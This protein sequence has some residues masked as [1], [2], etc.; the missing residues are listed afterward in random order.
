MSNL[1]TELKRRNVIRV[2]LLYAVFAW[3]ILQMADVLIP[4]LNL[5]E[6][7]DRLTFFLL[8]IGLPLAIFFAWAYEIT[9]EGLKREK[10]V[11]RSKS[12]THV[13]GRKIDF[14]IIGALVLALGYFVV[15]H[16]WDRDE[17]ATETAATGPSKKS[18]AVLPFAN[19]SADKE[20]EYFSDGLAETLLHR[21]AQ[22][23]DLRVAARTSSFQFREAGVDLKTIA[24]TLNVATI[25][26]GSVR[27]HR[28]KVRVTA[29]LINAEDGYHLW[30][31]EYDREID[32]I[33]AIQDE[34]ATN[35]VDALKVT[36]LGEEAERLQQHGT[37]NLAA[38]DAYLRGQA[39]LHEQSFASLQEAE[40]SFKDAIVLDSGYAD[41]YAGVADAYLNQADFGMIREEQAIEAALPMLERALELNGELPRAHAALGT[42]RGLQENWPAADASLS[43]ALELN[44]NDSDTLLK[45][46]DAARHRARFDEAIDIFERGLAI[47]PLSTSLIQTYAFVLTYNGR[48]DDALAQFKRL[49]TLAPGV[50]AGYFG[51]AVLYSNRGRPDEAIRW[52]KRSLEVDPDDPEIYA[53]LATYYLDLEDPETAEL[54]LERAEA[55]TRDNGVVSMARLALYVSRGETDDAVRFAEQVLASGQTNRFGSHNFMLRVLRNNDLAHGDPESAI[56][57]YEDYDEQLLDAE[58]AISGFRTHFRRIEVASALMA[59]GREAEAERLLRHTLQVFD[60]LPLDESIKDAVRSIIF[61]LLGEPEAVEILRRYVNSGDIGQWWYWYKIDPSYDSIRDKPEFQAIVAEVEQRVA[62]MRENLLREE[63]QPE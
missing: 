7:T 53:F 19:M 60:G 52:M 55:M 10:D 14:L 28:D 31:G 23:K 59:A 32:D 57:R 1:L 50:P 12:V 27:R 8:L 25:L 15:T 6:W 48:D 63:Q 9:P 39:Q 30:S 51:P 11:D 22:I 40:R 41:A 3:L 62:E 17:A 56:E 43:K 47:D 58:A 38:Y 45:M 42:V 24:E 34:I 5:P 36:L 29:Q 2:V 4:I 33:F 61:A 16:D 37:E 35:V 20:N 49:R 26:E 44:P 54:W 13:T 21:L 46:G 18:I